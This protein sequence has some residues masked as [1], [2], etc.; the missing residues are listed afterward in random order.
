MYRYSDV[1]SLKSQERNTTDTRDL[2]R[3]RCMRPFV[4]PTNFFGRVLG[5]GPPSSNSK[6]E[7]LRSKLEGLIP[8]RVFELQKM[9]KNT[10][11]YANILSISKCVRSERPLRDQVRYIS[12]S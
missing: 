12:S 10:F 2:S 6:G 9:E 3:A 8:S 5:K 7:P 11:L 1:D 4:P